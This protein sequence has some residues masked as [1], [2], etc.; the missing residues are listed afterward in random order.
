MTKFK[1]TGVISPEYILKKSPAAKKLARELRLAVSRAG[2]AGAKAM[3]ERILDS[4]TGTDWH[5]RRNAWRGMNR[6][7]I[8]G[9]DGPVNNSW[10]SRLETGN[11]YNSVSAN[12]GKIIPGADKRRM[13][14]IQGGFGWPASKDGNIRPAPSRPINRSRQPDS[15]NWGTDR[16]YFEMQEYGFGETPGM[17]AT[18]AG[19]EAA[20]K[21]LTEEINKLRR[22]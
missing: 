14:S 15:R 7:S 10:G 11:M 9:K 1:L 6:P 2:M 18:Q 20:R 16:N 19:V 21:K 12:Y 22:R 4:P 3:R 8:N 17:N 13:Q 5:V